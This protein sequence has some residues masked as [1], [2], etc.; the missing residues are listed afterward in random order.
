MPSLSFRPRASSMSRLPEQAD[1]PKRLFPK[2]AP[3]SSAQSTRRTVT[4]GLPLYCALMRRRIS[5]PASVFRATVE[6]AAVR[7]GIDV[8]A[9]EQRFLGFAA[10]RHPEIAR[11]VALD[12]RAELPRLSLHP[13]PRL[14]PGRGECD[15]LRAV[16]IA[17]SARSSFSSCDRSAADSSSCVHDHGTS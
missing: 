13:S 3:S 7:H 6:P 9:D 4:G 17:V 12:L 15:A 2:R 10:Q 11:F 8:A 14:R 1:E 16:F 5:T